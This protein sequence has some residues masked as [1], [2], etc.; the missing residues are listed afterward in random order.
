MVDQWSINFSPLGNI[1]GHQVDQFGLRMVVGS[2][3]RV[4]IRKQVRS[5]FN[6]E[7]YR[8]YHCRDTN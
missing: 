5:S 7:F 2:A 4:K 6:C 8:S 1:Q 3:S